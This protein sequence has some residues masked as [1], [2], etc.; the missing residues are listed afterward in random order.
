MNI[1]ETYAIAV[2]V[3]ESLQLDNVRVSH[4]P[5]DL[6]LSVLRRV[7]RQAR[8]CGYRGLATLKRLS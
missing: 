7:S 3:V 6:E 1:I 5:H 8:R 4:Y 2:G